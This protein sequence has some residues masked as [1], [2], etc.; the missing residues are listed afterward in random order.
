M[1][2]VGGTCLGALVIGGGAVGAYAAQSILDSVPATSIPPAHA[3]VTHDGRPLGV[4][5]ERAGAPVSL[6]ELRPHVV[7]AVLAIEDRRFTRRLLPI[8]LRGTARAALVNYHRGATVQGGSTIAQQLAKLRLHDTSPTLR[9]KVREALVATYLQTRFGKRRV[10]EDYLSRAPFGHGLVG[11]RAASEGYFGKPP[12]DLSLSEAAVLAGI[13]KASS[14]YNPV[15]DAAGSWAR[16]QVVLGEMVEEGHVSQAQALAARPPVLVLNDPPPARGYLVDALEK[17]L[18]QDGPRPPGDYA[19]TIDLELQESAER[20]VAATARLAA[21]S[22]AREVA[23]VAMR[24]DGRVV[25]MIGGRDYA[26][27]QFNR[28]TQAKRPIGSEAKT[29]VYVAALLAGFGPEDLVDDA[30]VRIGNWSPQNYDGKYLGPIPLRESLASSRN[31]ATVRLAQRVGLERVIA[32]ARRAGVTAPLDPAQPSF[33]LGST[34]MSPVEVASM[35]AG[36]TH[37]GPVAPHT[38]ETAGSLPAQCSAI[39]SEPKRLQLVAMLRDTLRLGTGRAAQFEGGGDCYAKT[40]TTNDRRDAWFVGA[41]GDLVVAVWA[42]NDNNQ[43]TRT[44]G[45]GLPALIWRDLMKEAIS[46]H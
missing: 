40:G 24:T 46:R 4:H 30:P 45:G 25:A 21:A 37:C 41:C 13:L 5:G 11:L 39:L 14:R 29:A 34:A 15:V 20:A 10:L 33:L 18:T 2:V 35:F 19:T 36:L 9:R 7:Q 43:P 12:S 32:V 6:D 17:E 22:G 42:G 38:F 3:F 28:A 23:L 26:R 8:D 44:D 1:A 31:A 27:S 16:A